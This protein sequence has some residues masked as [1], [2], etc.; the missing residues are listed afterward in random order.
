MGLPMRLISGT[1]LL[2]HNCELQSMSLTLP[3][4]K[5]YVTDF[6]SGVID[7]PP[8]SIEL[9]SFNISIQPSLPLHHLKEMDSVTGIPWV[10]TEFNVDYVYPVM[11]TFLGMLTCTVTLI[12]FLIFTK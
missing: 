1:F 5:R 7:I 9:P 8:T 2:P 10:F 4:M 3:A 12:I 11:V 6:E